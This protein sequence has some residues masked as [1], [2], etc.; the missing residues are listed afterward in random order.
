MGRPVDSSGRPHKSVPVY[1]VYGRH[2]PVTG[3]LLAILV[4]LGIYPGL[5]VAL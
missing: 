1:N 3:R 5:P 4:C 2:S